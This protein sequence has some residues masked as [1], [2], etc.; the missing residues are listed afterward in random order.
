MHIEA[1]SEYNMG[2]FYSPPLVHDGLIH[3]VDAKNTKS[4]P[5]SGT[6]VT[7]IAG[8]SSGTLTNATFN[9][10]GYLMKKVIVTTT[11]NHPTK[12]V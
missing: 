12:A 9:S 7:D 6:T 5:G 11:I 3:C 10:N 4:Y 2:T 8:T 1:D